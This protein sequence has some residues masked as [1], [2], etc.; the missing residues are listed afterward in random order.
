[1]STNEKQGYLYL[2][3]PCELIG[4]SNE[5]GDERF[6][7]GRGQTIDRPLH[8]YRKGTEI[9]SLIKVNDYKN[10]ESIL[11]KE[12]HNKFK[13]IAGCEFFE[14]NRSKIIRAFLQ[15]ILDNEE[16]ESEYEYES[17]SES[18]SEP[19]PEPETEPETV[20]DFFE[21]LEN[22]KIDIPVKYFIPPFLHKNIKIY[23]GFRAN[24]LYSLYSDYCATHNT[25][26]LTKRMFFNSAGKYLSK[27]RAKINGK[28][29]LVYQ[30]NYS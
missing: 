24:A 25:C 16:Y 21:D 11:I 7:I 15:C 13:C 22:D 14:G 4:V 17:E 27:T 12:F 1:M 8:G 3:Q 26:L 23:T 20:H 30:I 28:T 29:V 10:F 2:L 5:N 6:K 18:E 19:D 9:I